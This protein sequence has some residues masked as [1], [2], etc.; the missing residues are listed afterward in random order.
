MKK[1]IYLTTITIVTVICI[2]GG[3][4]YHFGNFFSFLPF[5]FWNTDA[6]NGQV[7]SSGTQVLEGFD[8]IWADVDVSSII[9]TRGENYSIDYKTTENIAPKYEVKNGTLTIK[10]TVK[11]HRSGGFGTHNRSCT[12]T[13]TVPKDT[14]LASIELDS[15]VGDIRLDSIVADRLVT[16]SSVGDT[17]IRQCTIESIETDS[18]VGDTKITGCTFLNLDTDND[19]G[20]IFVNSAKDL[21]DYEME[22]D[23]DIGNVTVNKHSHKRSYEQDGTDGSITLDNSTGDI[24]LSY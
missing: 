23:T 15:S 18:S 19:I 10:Q 21:S 16:D 14:T 5:S 4:I 6:S 1:G 20:D 3:S 8:N 9:I 22:L 2:I 12:I 17:E 24:S 7:S 13:I 11:H